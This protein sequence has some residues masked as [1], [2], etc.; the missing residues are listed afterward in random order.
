MAMV[1]P[2]DFIWMPRRR[3][4]VGKFFESKPRDL[5]HAIVDG[6]LERRRR[7]ARD[8][9]ADFVERVAH[10]ELRGELGNGKPGGLAGQGRAAAD[11]RVHLDHHHAAVF[12]VDGELDV[13]SAGLHADLADDGDGRVAHDLVL[14]VG[15]GL[16]RAPR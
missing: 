13:R 16:G 12:R 9:V 8:V 14:P 4:G 15:E 10:G 1:S 5:D 2:T 7:F 3:V 11:A 6:R